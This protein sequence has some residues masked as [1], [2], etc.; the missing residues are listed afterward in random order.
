MRPQSSRYQSETKTS[1][2]HTHIHTHT[3]Y[4]LISLMNIDVKIINKILVN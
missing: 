4:M 1:H 2:T 3:N